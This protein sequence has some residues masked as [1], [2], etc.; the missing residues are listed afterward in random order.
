MSV[1]EQKFEP[2]A[3]QV[4]G[5][6]VNLSKIKFS[7]K[8]INCNCEHY[9]TLFV[10]KYFIKKPTSHKNLSCYS[11]LELWQETTVAKLEDST[12]LTPKHSIQ[13]QTYA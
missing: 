12:P 9:V 4:Q 1:S 13:G 10:W 6:G 5:R 11:G 7:L 8:M 3:S 2:F